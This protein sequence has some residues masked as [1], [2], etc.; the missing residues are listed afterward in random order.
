MKTEA[1]FS[2]ATD[3]WQT[4]PDVYAALNLEFN[5]DLDPCPIDGNRDGLSPLFCTWHGRRVYCNPPYGRGLA[6]WLARGP[7]ADVAVFLIPARTDVRWFH[8]IVLPKAA[9]IRFLKGRLR[10]GDATNNAPFPS[11]LV[12]FRKQE[13]ENGTSAKT[14][15]SEIER[16]FDSIFD[17]LPQVAG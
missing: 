12:I 6:D 3:R 2:S 16:I 8:E 10:F 13:S 14:P 4:P 11:M 5:F 15:K 1:M 7:E 9:E 17:S